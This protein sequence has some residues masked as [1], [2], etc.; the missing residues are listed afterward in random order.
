MNADFKT[1]HIIDAGITVPPSNPIDPLRVK[2][3]TK[4]PVS[5]ALISMMIG[6]IGILRYFERHT[7]SVFLRPGYHHQLP[8]PN[9][10]P[11]VSISKN[12]TLLL[13]AVGL[14]GALII[15]RQ[16]KNK[17]APAQRNGPQPPSADRD[18]AFIALN[19]QYLNLQYKIT[20]HKFSGDHPPEGLLKEV[21][22]L[23]RKVRLI[24][25]ALDVS[26]PDP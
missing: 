9:G 20:Q 8:E 3:K 25:R 26:N 10:A 14:I 22:D 11:I 5:I 15:R 6:G 16:K 12:T 23:E 21:S 7:P 24:S 17:K 4:I 13:L 19:K 2:M 18:R 1:I